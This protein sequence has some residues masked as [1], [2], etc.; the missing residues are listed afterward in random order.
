MAS[1]IKGLN[2]SR[3]I[4]ENIIKGPGISQ[5]IVYGIMK[6]LGID[7]GIIEGTGITQGIIQDTATISLCG[8]GYTNVKEIQPII[9]FKKKKYRHCQ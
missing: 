9:P 4:I 3:G 2:I 5:G 1:V 7:Q 8:L 6:G